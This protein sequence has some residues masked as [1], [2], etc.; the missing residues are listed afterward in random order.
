[1]RRQ[2]GVLSAEAFCPQLNGGRGA[3]VWVNAT[4]LYDA[5]GRRLG[6]IETIRDISA[7]R[8]TAQRQ[9]QTLRRQE[10]INQLHNSL[11]GTE[12]LT[13]KLRHIT[14]LV[15]RTFSADFCRIWLVEPGDLC[16][17]GCMHAGAD[18]PQHR[19]RDRQHCLHLLASAGRY[20]HLDGKVHCRVPFGCYKIGR[21]ASGDEQKFVIRDVT[22]D[23]RVHDRDWARALGLRS[24]AG[25]QMRVPGGE[26]LGVLA[27][28]SM[29]DLSPDEDAQLEALANMTAQVVQNCRTD[30]ELR[31]NEER[32]HAIVA[33]THDGIAVTD[34]AG[35]LT[36]VNAA[37]CRLVART[38]AELIGQHVLALVPADEQEKLR[39]LSRRL[40]SEQSV[41]D[42]LRFRRPDHSVVQVEGSFV[43]ILLRSGAICVGSFRD[44][45]ARAATIQALRESE[46]KFRAL[47]EN[48]SDVIIRLDHE[49]RLLYA[50]PAVAGWSGK[51]PEAH[52]LR[53]FS[54]LGYPAELCAHWRQ[55]I[56]GMFA[57]QQPQ[58]F[59]F[60]LP[61]GRWFD[62]MLFP[63]FD[64]DGNMHSILATSR[65]VSE[66]KR[67][68]RELECLHSQQRALLDNIPDMIWFKDTDGRYL[69]ANQTFLRSCGKPEQ[70]VLGRDEAAVWPAPVA[71][72]LRADDETVLRNARQQRWEKTIDGFADGRRR[73]EIIK[74]PV[75][76]GDGTMLGTVGT[77]HDLTRRWLMEQELRANE[78]K[79]RTLVENIDLIV[80]RRL[81]LPDAL[82]LYANSATLRLFN[83]AELPTPERQRRLPLLQATWQ[84]GSAAHELARETERLGEVRN[85]EMV[86]RDG[87]G[88]ERVL[89]ITALAHRDDDGAIDYVDVV[90][91]DI[92]DERRLQ[93]RM[94][95]AERL[96]AL[97]RLSAA[98]AHE[99]NQPLNAIR[100]F[101]QDIVLS[102]RDGLPVSADEVS[103]NLGKA[104]EQV[105]RLADIIRN[106]RVFVKNGSDSMME[107]VAVARLLRYPLALM[108]AQ[109]RSHGIELEAP[110]P[111]PALIVQGNEARLQQVLVNLLTNARDAV[112]ALAPGC[113]RRITLAAVGDSQQR[114]VRITVCDT[115]SGMRLE[116]VSKVFEP[117]FTTKGP[118]KGTGLGLAVSYEIVQQHSGLLQAQV[119]PEGGMLFTVIL[120]LVSE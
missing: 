25:Y 4:G 107:K 115:G 69:A 77:A 3:Y 85:R 79:Y 9:E 6:A 102:Y 67:V 23:E 73:M 45:T 47:A 22:S 12:L 21:I 17:S 11:L 5:T 62:S 83:L 30:E 41:H 36:M 105:D 15:V 26:T 37:F 2:G 95:Q 20:T 76:G 13:D 33:N 55:V 38:E 28:F 60:Q 16:A 32:F 58:R 75:R 93:Q 54:D 81:P 53:T 97:G 27:L 18:D 19:C 50:N 92:T 89:R 42:E 103:F 94:T 71:E 34:P 109:L 59:E 1:M 106:M 29:R 7:I 44:I 49:H 72:S 78:E 74:T 113:P 14:E 120:P 80:Y 112:L 63:E 24:F 31:E 68:A 88:R 87:Q 111:D 40:I 57:G 65:D 119:M 116:D 96:A 8:E 114:K 52:L 35:V 10:A 108:E 66:N 90:G 46:E 56:D 101:C 61:D 86:V 98:V 48:T 118:D 91:E 64:Q 117:F 43:V 99:M 104:V 70:A 39:A 100:N 84:P 51:P 110:A 82:L